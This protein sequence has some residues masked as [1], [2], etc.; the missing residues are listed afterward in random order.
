MTAII[1]EHG[2]MLDKYM[3]DGLMAVFGMNPT[4]SETEVQAVSAGLK[5]LERLK[6]NLR[7]SGIAFEVGIGINTGFVVAGYVGT[8]ERV[9]FTVLGDPVNVAHRLE[10]MARPN[11]V[12]I[13][14][15][16][17]ATVTGRFNLRHLG[18]VELRGRSQTVQA[19]EVFS[20]LA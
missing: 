6:R 10:T 5:M 19:H 11:R 1:F 12:V 7:E 4:Q 8:A 17:A 20:K 18:A 3:G 2:G 9:E 14:P 13:G 16:T 15:V